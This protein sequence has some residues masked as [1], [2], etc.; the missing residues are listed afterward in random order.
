MPLTAEGLIELAMENPLNE[1]IF[2]CLPALG[3]N[4]C[5]LTAG[6]LFQAASYQARWPWLKIIEP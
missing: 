1:Q 5:M 4:Q 2:S 6:C 3:L